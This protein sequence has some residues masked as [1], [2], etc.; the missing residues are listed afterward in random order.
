MLFLLESWL[1]GLSQKS[2]LNVLIGF[3]FSGLAHALSVM[4]C[5]YLS[6]LNF[7]LHFFFHYVSCLL[8]CQQQKIWSECNFIA[9]SKNKALSWLWKMC[10]S[11]WSSLC[12]VGNMCR[13]RQ[14]LSILVCT[15]FLFLNFI[16]NLINCVLN[17]TLDSDK[18]STNLKNMFYLGNDWQVVYIWGICFMHLDWNMVH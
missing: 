18:I 5:R 3:Y 4:L 16:L 9:A 11:V 8:M 1:N 14:P 2:W 13:T 15:S 6:C 7:F 10:S 12:L 17:F